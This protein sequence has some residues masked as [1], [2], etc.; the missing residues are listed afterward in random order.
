MFSF[1]G[2]PRAVSW[3]HLRGALA[4]VSG[5]LAGSMASAATYYLDAAN[6]NDSWA[7]TAQSASA[8]NGPWRSLNRLTAASLQ[9]GDSVLLACGQTWNETLRFTGSGTSAARIRIGTFPATCSTAPAIDGAVGLPASAWQLH[10]GQVYKATLGAATT[11]P[12]GNLA[13]TAAGWR[14]YSPSA[15]ATLAFD[16]ACTGGGFGCLRFTTG[17]AAGVNALITPP[18]AVTA[19]LT[20]N[21]TMRVLAPAGRSFTVDLRRMS[22]PYTLGGM[23]TASFVGTGAWQTINVSFAPALSVTDAR[24]DV[25]VPGGRT[26]LLLRDAAATSTQAAADVSQVFESGVGVNVAHHPNRGFNSTDPQ[27]VF[28]RTAQAS[29]TFTNATGRA[30]SNYLVTGSDLALPA[31]ATI[32]AGLKLSV[33]SADWD[34]SEHSVSSY[35]GNTLRFTPD[36]A[37]GL[38]QAGW[39]YFFTGALWMVDS[40]GEWFFDTAASTL[41]LQTSTGAAPSA[42]ITYSTLA[43]GADLKNKSYVTVQGIAFRRVHTGVEMSGSTDV[44]LQS[45]QISQTVGFGVVATPAT[46]P[47][48]NAST[49]SDTQTDAIHA[50]SAKGIQVTGNTILNSGVRVAANG[51]VTSLPAP[52]WAAVHAGP[53][54][55]VHDNRLRHTAHDG[56]SAG[57]DSTI[58]SNAIEV[59]CLSLNDCGGIHTFQVARL[60]IQNNLVVDGRGSVQGTPTGFTLHTAGIYLDGHTSASQVTGNTLA[61][62][63]WGMQLLDSY[64]NTLSG[65]TFYGN[66][67]HQLWTQQRQN[68]VNASKGDVFGNVVQYNQFFPTGINVSVNQTSSTGAPADMAAYDFNQYSTLLASSIAVEGGPASNRSYTFADWQNAVNA[69][70][71]ARGLDRSG[72][73]AAPLAGRAIGIMGGELMPN[74]NLANGLTDWG[75]GGSHSNPTLSLGPCPAGITTCVRV[76]SPATNTWSLL[77][78]PKFSAV[79]GAWY[80]ISFDAAVSNP[81]V[82]GISVAVRNADTYATISPTLAASGS[83]SWKRYAFTFQVT[84]DT[85]ITANASG[86][87]VDFQGIVGGQW[88]TVANVQLTTMTAGA[89]DVPY[90]LIYNTGRTASFPACP[91]ANATTCGNFV[92]FSDGAAI[93]WPTQ[94]SPL[95]SRIIFAPDRNLVD[96]DNDGIADHQ[97]SCAATPTG[98]V[99]NNRGCSL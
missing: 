82:Q 59:F 63:D 10:R 51:Q 33:R 30:V 72:R 94:L 49:I 18:F 61:Y 97:D 31:G 41:Y 66:R 96:S 23:N 73:V 95:Q 81:A 50:F 84:T 22:A 17:S 75:R 8:G 2:S 42:S 53:N 3:A 68:V 9:P 26:V 80:R 32:T 11:I 93:S 6:G 19:G 57:D 4:M 25:G 71:A 27:S 98:S 24:L 7:G 13:Q 5:L 69:V 43:L 35:S 34:V 64:N 83:S 28:L 38:S 45:V 76:T 60:K 91:V 85:P 15:D 89:S 29:S 62:A 86:A 70:G 88:L 56:I 90:T 78:T 20:H 58:G 77:A 99:V 21:V 48:I 12:N 46:N 74:G 39:G 55:L 65:N 14:N 1:S 47:V 79:K 52:A 87:R 67:Q 37:Y 54:A 92:A 44:Q 16:A 36:S 40:P